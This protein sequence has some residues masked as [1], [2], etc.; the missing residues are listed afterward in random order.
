MKNKYICLIAVLLIIA[1]FMAYGRI[2]DNG[3]INYDDNKYII[4]NNHIKSGINAD[5]V[6]W[7]FTTLYFGYWHPVTWISH[8]LDWN[9]FGTNA[10]SH[11]LINLLLHIGSVLLLFFFMC[12]VTKQIWPSAFV[13]ALF[14]LHPLRVESVAWAAERKDVLSMFLG[15]ASIYTYSLYTEKHK[16]SQY[17]ICFL[18]FALS[19]MS[20]PLWVTLPFILLL[21]DYWPLGRWTIGKSPTST[22]RLIGEKIPFIFLTVIFS[23]VTFHAQNSVGAIPSMEKLPFSLRIFNAVHSYISYLQKTFWPADLSVFYPYEY[24]FL[25]WQ[26]ILSCCILLGISAFVV[27]YIKKMP[28]LFVGWFWYLGTLIPLIGFVQAGMHAMADRHTYLPSVGIAI[29]LAWGIPLLFLNDKIR[30]KILLPAGIAILAI[31]AV[32]TWKQ[33]GYWKNSYELF[34][35]ALYVTKDNYVAY[36]SRGITY[37]ELGQFNLA[38]RDFNEAIR[39]KPDY[40]RAYNNRGFAYLLQGE[41]ILG[42]SDAQRACKLGNCKTLEFAK[43]KGYCR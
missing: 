6:K 8:M 40:A 14:A 4:E 26:I 5:S 30:K 39:L 41:M 42:C 36:N 7:A 37:G 22:V 32:L 16:L 20:K 3:F 10:S 21:L 13:S 43:S 2:L 25:S 33:C 24:S 27:C 17:F 23:L 15:M 28:F 29:M 19:L 34:N 12:Q 38:I 35:H 1:S 31:F 11:H 9:L 18:L